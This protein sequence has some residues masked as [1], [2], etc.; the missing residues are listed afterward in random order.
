MMGWSEDVSRLMRAAD[1]FVFPRL[2]H[3][4]EGLGLVVVEAQCAGLPVFI[5][6]GIVGDA[7]ELDELAHWDIPEN[8][9]RWAE[10]IEGVL[11]DGPR[12]SREAALARMLSSRFEISVASANLLAHYH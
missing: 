10:N 9:T 8:P 5:T 4:R 11:A 1:A 3:P 7:V 6:P 2:E 12:I